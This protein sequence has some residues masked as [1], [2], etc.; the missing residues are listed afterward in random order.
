L[1]LTPATVN[2][3][4]ASSRVTPAPTAPPV[5]GIMSGTAVAV[6]SGVLS[7]GDSGSPA[8]AGA[9]GAGAGGVG[10]GGAV[11]G[12]GVLRGGPGC[13]RSGPGSERP[14]VAAGSWAIEMGTR[15]NANAEVNMMNKKT[16]N[17]YPHTA[18]PYCW[19]ACI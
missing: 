18:E 2:A 13:G 12:G 11:G 10:A 17:T 15:G 19:F 5:L 16:V 3:R 14:G 6:A 4:P 8:G 9:G 1:T 7:A